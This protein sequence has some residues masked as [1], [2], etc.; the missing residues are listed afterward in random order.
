MLRPYNLVP[1][2]SLTSFPTTVPCIPLQ[3]HWSPGHAAL[4]RSLH[5]RFTLP[6]VLFPGFLQSSLPHLSQV[7]TPMSTP[8][9]REVFADHSIRGYSSFSFPFPF[10]TFAGFQCTYL[11]VCS[12]CFI[13]ATPMGC[14][15]L[16]VGCCIYFIDRFSEATTMLDSWP[17]SNRV[18][19]WMN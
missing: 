15:L 8:H 17:A 2:T 3:P 10:A 5:Q 4:S 18:V 19:E 1:I 12:F 6:G 16:Q 7:P 9:P 14:K 13:S 11:L